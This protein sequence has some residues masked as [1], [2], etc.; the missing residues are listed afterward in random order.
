M[1]VTSLLCLVLCSCGVGVLD[2]GEPEGPKQQKPAPAAGVRSATRAA[3]GTS[4]EVAC[5]STSCAALA[6]GP[7]DVYSCQDGKTLVRCVGAVP[8]CYACKPGHA[9]FFNNGGA[10]SDDVCSAPPASASCAACN[11]VAAGTGSIWACEESES[12]LVRCV[13]G[14]LETKACASGCRYN[15]GGT[16]A[17]DY[18]PSTTQPGIPTGCGQL[19]RAQVE[20]LL[21]SAG[22]PEWSIPEMVRIAWC[23]S[24]FYPCAIS[25]ASANPGKDWGLFQVSADHW[26]QPGE[27][28]YVLHDPWVNVTRAK[29]VFD[30]QGYAGW[31]CHYL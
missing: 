12:R 24:E 15:N 19:S 28:P 14:C 27:S 21:R 2:G 23:E 10:W 29:Q 25:K 1:R 7:Y 9:C 26:L 22:F 17:D 8:R 13:K 20:S 11:A 5:P 6:S 31:V 3:L 18:C 4:G 16:G 30:L